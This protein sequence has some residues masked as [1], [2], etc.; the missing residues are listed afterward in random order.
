M[1]MALVG[2]GAS[3]IAYASGA[4]STTTPQR[5]TGVGSTA[6][7]RPFATDQGLFQFTKFGRPARL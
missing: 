4:S 1:S 3:S 7:S 2:L 5:G 6:F